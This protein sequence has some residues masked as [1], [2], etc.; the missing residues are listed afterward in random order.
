MVALNDDEEATIYFY[1]MIKNHA[2]IC[3]EFAQNRKPGY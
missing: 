2:G 1:D 3:V